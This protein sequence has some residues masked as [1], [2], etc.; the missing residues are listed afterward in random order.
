MSYFDCYLIPVPT[1]KLAAYKDFS[2][3]MA[4]VYREHGAVRL[5]DCVLDPD[6]VDGA[7]FHADGAQS[8]LEGAALRGFPA[9][10]A[11]REGETVVLSWTEWPSKEAR[12]AALPRVLADPRVQPDDDQE[13]IFEGRRLIAG[14]FLALLDLAA[15]DRGGK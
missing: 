1:A 14:G 9:A 15:A 5:V 12:D 3:R 6:T 4:V 13:M 2:A 10:A 8:A 11:V 7:Q